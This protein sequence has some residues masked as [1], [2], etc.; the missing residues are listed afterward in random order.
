VININESF[1]VPAPPDVV[2]A[3]LSDPAAVVSCVE[4]AELGE[5]FDDGS[6]AGSLLVKFGPMRVK[7]GARINVE[8]DEVARQG[9]VTAQGKDAQ[10]GTRMK[11]TAMFD[12]AEGA[13]V[14]AS[15]VSATGEVALSGKLAQVVEAGASVVVRHLT[16]EFAANLAVLCSPDGVG[17]RRTRRGWRRWLD[18]VRRWFRRDQDGP[19]VS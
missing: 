2:L 10:G 12:V 19:P 13:Q 5:Q 18:A 6:F 1:E 4:G 11:A 17:P 15:T 9:R 7:F 8:V 14:G 3:K 16:D